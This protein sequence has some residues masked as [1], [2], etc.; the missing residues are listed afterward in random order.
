M[1]RYSYAL[2]GTAFMGMVEVQGGSGG[3]YKVED[4][5]PIVDDLRLWLRLDDD[6]RRRLELPHGW[7]AQQISLHQLDLKTRD[8]CRDRL[9]AVLRT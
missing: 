7:D 1:Q 8:E 6:L 5:D 2:N 9:R 3:F 4:V